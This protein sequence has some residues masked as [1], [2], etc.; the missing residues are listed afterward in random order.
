MVGT[1][2]IEVGGNP[3]AYRKI[4]L[5][6]KLDT[7][8]PSKFD[9]VVQYSGS[10]AYWD[11]VEIKRDNITEWKGFVEDKDDFWDK[12]GHFLNIGGRDT[13]LI[14][15]KKWSEGFVDMHEATEGFFG[16]VSAIEL[17]KFLLRCPKS[18]PTGE[19]PYNKE[20]WGIDKSKISSCRASR[21]SV[22]D[23]NW[24]K[25]RKRGYGWRN[26]GSPY[27]SVDA[28]VDA[29]IS[30]NWST[31]GVSP[32]INAE[33]ANYIYSKTAGQEGIF[34]FENLSTLDPTVTSVE[35]CFLNILWRPEASWWYADRARVK[36]YISP[37]GGT[38]WYFA[39]YFDGKGSVFGPVVWQTYS[40][41]V[42]SYIDTV[43]KADNARVKLVCQENVQLYAY[44][45]HVYLTFSYVT[46]GSQ[47]YINDEFDVVLSCAE[48]LVG[49]YMESRIDNE[50]FPIN[51]GVLGITD[52]KQDYTT[53]TDVDGH[54]TVA[55]THIDFNAPM[56]ADA[57]VYKDFGA[58]YFD[59]YFDHIFEVKVIP[60]P[61]TAFARLGIWAVTNTID[62]YIGL[63]GGGQSNLAMAIQDGGGAQPYFSLR[64]INNGASTIDTGLELAE[65]TTYMIW[66]KRRAGNVKAYIYTGGIDGQLFDTLELNMAGPT[67]TFRYLFACLS[68][69]G[70]KVIHTD[71]DIDNL[72]IQT[73]TD[74]GYVNNNTLRDVIHSWTPQSISHLRIRITIDDAS[75]SWAISQ[76]YLYK[77]EDLDYRVW[78]ETGDP[79]FPDDQYIQDFSADSAY[80]TAFGPLNIPKGR[81]LDVINDI[82]S[83]CNAS[84]VPFEFWL[85]LDANNTF[86]LKNQKGTA[87]GITFAKATNLG[88]VTNSG[89]VDE[90][91][92]RIQIIG[93]AEGKR[94]E[95]V[96]SDWTEDV[97]EMGN[98]NTFYEDILTEKTIASKAV[99][100]LLANIELNELAPPKEPKDV[101]IT[102]DTNVSMTYDVGDTATFTD[103]LTSLSGAHRIYNIR[104]TIDNN[105]EVITI[106]ID[107]KRRIPEEQIKDIYRRLKE[108]GLV[109]VITSDWVGEA[110]NENKI[111]SKVVTESFSKT[112]KNGEES[113]KDITDPSWYVNP[114]PTGY[115]PYGN[116]AAGSSVQFYSFANG[117]MWKHK[118]DW[119]GL[120]GPNAG[121]GADSFI[122]ERRGE[123]FIDELDVIMNQNPKFEAE[124]RAIRDT[125]GNINGGSACNWRVGDYV[126]LGMYDSANSYGFF[127]RL[128]K[129]DAGNILKV[130]ACWNVNATD[131]YTE[132]I[133][134]IDISDHENDDVRYKLEILTEIQDDNQ[135]YVIFNVYDLNVEGQKYPPSSIVANV[136]NNIVIKPFYAK[137]SADR[138]ADAANLCILYIYSY[139][140][141]WEKLN[142]YY[143]ETYGET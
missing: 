70:S 79:T 65:G 124:I 24:V 99:A 66:I 12:D 109:G 104:K 103:S 93:K 121:T 138:H 72:T 19:F 143:S 115:T 128:I 57:Y 60:D 53:Y 33:D 101:L 36:A 117:K 5:E 111:D 41:D 30:N 102:R 90:T 11:L 76:I 112:A 85:A 80:T 119:I 55:A 82:V 68:V 77:A 123:S 20:G 47:S 32:Y 100:D 98:V 126:E 106:T 21:T 51:Y 45:D 73:Y 64:E 46:G 62:D 49:L 2:T 142:P 122:V 54:T 89:S 9:A 27:N 17:I 56:D 92:Q 110:A 22:G 28:D 74:L 137:L 133:R 108:L 31:N 130:Y 78:L 39:G 107:S 140:I 63:S 52:N 59:A 125:T 83:Q 91:V 113:D 116:H 94:Q 26:S 23:P 43:S 88:G 58:G 69:N 3:I 10:I 18:D 81:L 25:L 34:S 8:I 129:E 127:F 50:S 15:W 132:L 97:T 135:K 38:T 71:V 96:S 120:W 139:R 42:S 14:L 136:D 6:R 44:I 13:T 134:E 118:S 48:T 84:Y 37:D 86:H 141:E 114:V 61:I 105:G 7:K 4:N 1:W 131:E 87:S 35:K 40:F 95:K 67:N 29:L 16:S 75:H